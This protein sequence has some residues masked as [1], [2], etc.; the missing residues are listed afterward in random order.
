MTQLWRSSDAEIESV[1]QKFEKF[2][3]WLNSDATLTQKKNQSRNLRPDATS[4]R[5][6]AFAGNA[7]ILWK[8]KMGKKEKI[9]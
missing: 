2:E 4:W 5:S 8:K 9:E 3:K 1:G 6:F 7:P